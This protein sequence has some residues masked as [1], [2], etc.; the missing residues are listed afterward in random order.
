MPADPQRQSGGEDRTGW[1][2][3]NGR[4]APGTS[5]APGGAGARIM[6]VDDMADVR[7]VLG[8][9]LT[10]EGY[11]I[12][13]VGDARDALVRL[14]TFRPSVIL[15][16]ILMP[17]LSGFSALQQIRARDPDVGVIMVTGNTDAE[18]ARQTL[19][20]GAFDYVTKPIDF[21]YLKRSIETFLLMRPLVPE[22]PT[23]LSRTRPAE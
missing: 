9:Y 22:E 17:G 23:Q 7:E 8:E 15:L 19:A 6:V 5:V 21:A 13:T 16:D 10:S 20:L 4:P 12:N 18:L 14:A 3:L 11:T 2:P 1:L